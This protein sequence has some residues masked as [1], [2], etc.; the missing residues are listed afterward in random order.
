[1]ATFIIVYCG[2][3]CWTHIQY[4]IKAIISLSNNYCM[5]TS[6]NIQVCGLVLMPYSY[7]RLLTTT[8]SPPMDAHSTAIVI[9]F[10]GYILQEQLVI[11]V[12]LIMRL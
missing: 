10:F 12:M 7:F 11:D 1:M 8:P 6:T 2:S 9:P 3:S 4:N 5:S